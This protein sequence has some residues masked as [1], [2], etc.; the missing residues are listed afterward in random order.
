MLSSDIIMESALISVGEKHEVFANFHQ[1]F[2]FIF[3]LLELIPIMF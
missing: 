2:P 1:F 3:T